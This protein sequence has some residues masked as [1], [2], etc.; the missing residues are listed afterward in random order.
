[1]FR[2]EF[3]IRVKAYP[4][5]FENHLCHHARVVI[6]CNKF[7]KFTLDCFISALLSMGVQKLMIMPSVIY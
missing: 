4:V 1:M 7:L 6:S 5:G 2:S 3:T